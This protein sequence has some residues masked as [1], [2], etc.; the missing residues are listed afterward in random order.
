M[1]LFE[2]TKD[3]RYRKAADALRDQ[4]R[5]QPR[6]SDGGFWHKL[7]Y[8]RQMWLDGLYMAEPFYAQY[9]RMF[10]DSAAFNDI[11][12][13]FI[14]VARHTRDAKTG[15]FYHAW[16]EVR[17]QPWADLE[18]GHSPNIW[19]RAMGW[20]AMAL[21]DVL[22]YLPND[23]KDRAEIVRTLQD[24]AKAVERVQDPSTGLWWQILDQPGRPKN[25]LEASAS[26]MFVY[27]LAKG[28]RKG[29]LP[30]RARAVA[31]RGFDGLIKQLVQM[32]ANGLPSLTGICEVA[33]LGGAPR[34][35]G[36]TRDGSYDYYVSEPVVADDY[37]GLGPFIMA[38]LEL[39]R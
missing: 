36:S 14:L 1:A 30:S 29:Y 16:D 21:V 23:H 32:D 27:A 3:A 31:T 20:Y 5:R 10:G 37:K 24:L 38:A 13:Q 28:A 12:T 19:G 34:K 2:R 22:D 33:G 25:Y 8:P 17:A 6:T 35:D 18:T 26:S 7:I 39:G 11:A 4:L 15:L 9:A